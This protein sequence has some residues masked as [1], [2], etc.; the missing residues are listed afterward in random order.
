MTLEAEVTEAVESTGAS[1]AL[2]LRG[3]V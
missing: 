3:C 1:A 2:I